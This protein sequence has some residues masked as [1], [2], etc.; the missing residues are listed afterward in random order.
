[1]AFDV[2][3]NFYLILVHVIP[4]SF[5]NKHC[6]DSLINCEVNKPV[7]ETVDLVS[8]EMALKRNDN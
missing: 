5:L 6:E 1:M 8:S 4:S 3:K 2:V 7:N